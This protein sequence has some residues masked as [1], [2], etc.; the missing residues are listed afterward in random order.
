MQV[1]CYEAFQTESL[2]YLSLEFLE[3]G[4]LFDR[5]YNDCQKF[6]ESHAVHIVK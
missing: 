1:K 5:I 6:T 3:G 4:E 2:I